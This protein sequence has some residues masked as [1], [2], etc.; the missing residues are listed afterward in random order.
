[1]P[2]EPS[3]PQPPIHC[4]RT[5]WQRL[6]DLRDDLETNEGLLGAALAI[7]MHADPGLDPDRVKRQLAHWSKEIGSRTSGRSAR[8]VVAHAHALLFD[9]VGLRGDL[10]DYG[11]PLN[12]LI[13]TVIERRRGLPISLALVYKLVV[14]AAGP[15]V[16]HGVNAPGHFLVRVEAA[17]PGFSPMLVDPFHAGRTLSTVEALE[18]V[19]SLVGD[20]VDSRQDPLPLASHRDWVLRILRNLVGV[21][22]ERQ[23]PVDRAAMEELARLL[24]AS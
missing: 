7:A 20:V 16:V 18:L 24:W 6:R 3:F 1:V 2:I 4:R 23:R 19:R 9:E 11:N 21:Y 13:H 12:S 10:E 15:V 8:A 14:E 5:A 17:E 22:H